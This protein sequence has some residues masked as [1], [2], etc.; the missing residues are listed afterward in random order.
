MS[1]VVRRPRVGTA[2]RPGD[3]RGVRNWRRIRSAKY[4]LIAPVTSQQKSTT[5][6]RFETGQKAD[7]SGK[8]CSRPAVH[9][10]QPRR[11][12]SGTSG[13]RN[14]PARGEA[15]LETSDSMKTTTGGPPMKIRETQDKN[16]R[17]T[18][19]TDRAPDFRG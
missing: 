7:W 2:M 13:E 12:G 9:A 16:D 1:I 19:E 8:I 6:F 17:P 10:I 14:G 15:G 11:C 3:A 18:T 5:S 4:K